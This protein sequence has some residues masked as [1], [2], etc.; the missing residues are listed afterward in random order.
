MK[1]NRTEWVRA[2][3]PRRE[4]SQGCHLYSKTGLSQI[5]LVSRGKVGIRWQDLQWPWAGWGGSP[6]MGKPAAGSWSPSRGRWVS[7]QQCGLE[8]VLELLHRSN[9]SNGTI[10]YAQG[11]DH[12]GK[13]M[14][15]EAAVKEGNYKFGKR[16]LK[17]TLWRRWALAVSAW[18]H[19][20]QY[21]LVDM[22]INV[23]K[24]CGWMCIY[25]HTHLFPRMFFLGG[26]RSNDII[27][28]IVC[29]ALRC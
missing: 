27:I 6:R 13:Y 8:W 28:A 14:L 15:I 24:A 21:I 17:W 3:G 20:F 18:T 11:I 7:T 10:R 12:I 4:K 22:K 9:G 25:I 2:W 26:P 29:S 1:I 16:K 5:C 19:G 23:N